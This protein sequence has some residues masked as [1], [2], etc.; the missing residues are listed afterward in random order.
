MTKP[1]FPQR[2]ILVVDDEAFVC[3]AVRMMLHFDGHVVKTTSNGKDALT[4]LGE[5]KF[6]LVIT[7]YEMPGMK[8]D[9]LA[10]EIKHRNPRQ[11]VVMITAY[12]EMLQA[13]GKTMAGV[14][15]IIGKPFLLED[16]R[17]A[18]TK[19]TGSGPS[20]VEPAA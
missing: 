12:K 8:G 7:D 3:D 16:L 15:C 14:D 4:T 17:Q 11:P 18:I 1:A 19:T 2:H 5:Q 13:S 6:D 10:S 20:I 9:A